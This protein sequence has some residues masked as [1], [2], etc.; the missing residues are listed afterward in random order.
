MALLGNCVNKSRSCDRISLAIAIRSFILSNMKC[1]WLR[2]ILTPLMGLIFAVSMSASVVQAADMAIKMTIASSMD[3]ADAGG[4]SDCG[5]GT[6]DMKASGCNSAIC[7][8][9]VVAALPHVLVALRIDGVD[10]PTFA[11]PSLVGWAPAPDPYPPRS[12]ILG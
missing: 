12:N 7:A 10:V 1:S 5:G 8:A 9:Q 4:C 2:R 11:Q 3:V 6:S